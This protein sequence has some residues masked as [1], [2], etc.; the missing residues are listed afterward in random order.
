M[1][2]NLLSSPHPFGLEIQ[3]RPP[4]KPQNNKSESHHSFQG[5]VKNRLKLVWW[6][7]IYN[8]EG[9]EFVEKCLLMFINY[10]LEQSF[11]KQFLKVPTQIQTICGNLNVLIFFYYLFL[12]FHVQ[13]GA[14]SKGLFVHCDRIDQMTDTGLIQLVSLKVNFKT[15]SSDLS[16]QEKYN[17]F[18]LMGSLSE[19]RTGFRMYCR[20]VPSSYPNYKLQYFFIL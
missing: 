5:T 11:P 1:E 4:I 12:K 6:P 17:P 14:N 8:G 10:F 16:L 19:E 2:E 20:P 7:K 9:L 18:T 3:K 15:V 13:K